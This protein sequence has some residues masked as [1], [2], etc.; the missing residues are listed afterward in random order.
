MIKQN[1]EEKC[2]FFQH[3]SIKLTTREK[4][5]FVKLL[6]SLDIVKGEYIS[7]V[8]ALILLN[9]FKRSLKELTI[10][11]STRKKS[12]LIGNIHINF[13]YRSLS[14]PKEIVTL[15]YEDLSIPVSSFS[16]T[17]VD[18]VSE[19][20]QSLSLE[21]L[22][23]CFSN[24]SG[25]IKELL[26]IAKGVSDSSFK[27]CLF[28]LVWTGKMSATDLAQIRISETPI[29]LVSKS[30]GSHYIW[31]GL[32]SIHFPALLLEIK[33]SLSKNISNDHTQ[34][35]W[36]EFRRYP[37]FH[38]YILKHNWLPILDDPRTRKQNLIKNFML[39]E[40]ILRKISSHDRLFTSIYQKKMTDTFEPSL[41]NFCL[42]WFSENLKKTKLYP[43]L[44]K[45][46]T[47]N[48]N[49]GSTKYLITALHF[50]KQLNM[51]DR[52][53]KCIKA[54]GSEL[55]QLKEF[56]LI[57]K[58]LKSL[59]KKRE[60]LSASVYKLI[61]MLHMREG[62]IDHAILTIKNGLTRF[63]QS[64]Y[65]DTSWLDLQILL[66]KTYM[67]IQNYDEAMIHLEKAKEFSTKKHP[68]K[69]QSIHLIRGNYEF[70]QEN[71]SKAKNQY[72]KALACGTKF[73]INGSNGKVLYNLGLIEFRRSNYVKSS[74][75]FIKSASEYAKLKNLP[76]VIDANQ[77]AAMALLNVGKLSKAIDLLEQN[78]ELLQQ[79]GIKEVS[80][81][82]ITT[83]MLAW[84][85]EISGFS[86]TAIV[87]WQEIENVSIDR[88]SERAS[89]I[90]RLLAVN[91]DMIKNNLD[92]ALT[93]VSKMIVEQRK[94]DIINE[95]LAELLFLKGQIELFSNLPNGKQTLAEAAKILE[96]FPNKDITCRL[97]VFRTVYDQQDINIHR[98]NGLLNK[99]VISEIFDPFWPW[100][101][102]KLMSLQLSAGAKF[103]EIQ[104]KMTTK[105]FMEN[106]Q[107]RFVSLK[108]F[109]IHFTSLEEL[110]KNAR[111]IKL[112]KNKMVSFETVK[113][114]RKSKFDGIKIDAFLG[115]IK[116]KNRFIKIKKE[117]Y[118]SKLLTALIEG[119]PKVSTKDLFEAAWGIEYDPDWDREALKASIYR[120]RKFI[121]PLGTEISISYTTCKKEEFVKITINLPWEAII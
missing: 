84:A 92:R 5:H 77:G 63:S 52:I 73:Y 106:M 57:S 98:L 12:R 60:N 65:K 41:P 113:K 118:P 95:D 19:K 11:S 121:K 30:K 4:A 53:I 15:V 36:I 108:S 49:H 72:L 40:K 44:K 48:L 34:S 50:G 85:Y 33:P 21:E 97:D 62:N 43:D 58:Y 107:S 102:E 96:N 119:Y 13:I 20:N 99:L 100:Y 89:F 31:E 87:L 37:P 46:V 93:N 86:T 114:W 26:R 61:S 74:Q 35:A 25:Q 6:T 7:H 8:S 111:L 110:P 115:I 103:L 38:K 68:S 112:N 29:Y 94:S 79:H 71:L 88:L 56:N 64:D 27:R 81:I 16:T 1:I 32:I 28:W 80:L 82:T 22:S 55:L 101:A 23:E 75:M 69:L 18:L 2:P 17:L 105:N 76:V 78:R 3:S 90:S 42:S 66:A 116:I 109:F 45:W 51:K 9:G 70:S 10:V 91:S 47:T 67:Q 39:S 83:C 54:R 14:K 120:L 117:T 24:Y 104:R 59:E